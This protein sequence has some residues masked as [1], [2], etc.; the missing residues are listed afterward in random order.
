MMISEIHL[1][2]SIMF[3]RQVGEDEQ[4]AARSET[5]IKQNNRD[6]ALALIQYCY[7]ML[8]ANR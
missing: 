8:A 7:S 6:L 4:V 3:D 1:W 5:E 2:S